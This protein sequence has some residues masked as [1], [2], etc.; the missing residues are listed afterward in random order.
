[1][2]WWEE[3]KGILV[4]ENKRLEDYKLLKEFSFVRRNE[5]LWLLGVVFIDSEHKFPFYFE[6]KYPN[7][8]PFAPP[9]IYPK[10]KSTGW[11]PG[12]QFI[13]EGRFCLDIREYNWL[14]NMSAVNIIESMRIL[15]LASFDK[16]INKRKKLNV[17]EGRE[18]TQLEIKTK[19]IRCLYSRD[20][21]LFNDL[22]GT[23]DYF[24]FKEWEDNRIIIRTDLKD[25]ES[26]FKSELFNIW[27]FNIFFS[28]KGVYIQTNQEI[29]RLVSFCKTLFDFYDLL[30]KHAGIKKEI[31]LDQLKKNDSV[32]VL[33]VNEYKVPILL[34]KIDTKK[35]E[36]QH[37]GCY[38]I[39]FNKLQDRLPNRNNYKILSHKKLQ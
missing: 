31:L 34:I 29:I 38:K 11:V 23:F 14:S 4:R 32:Y 8:Y 20:L 17:K 6:C 3:Q 25:F 27:D 9:Y 5:N 18:P 10:D 7:S 22:Y 2:N 16:Y 39:D 33:L 28:K 13:L 26:F 19:E 15:V 12:H 37:Y 35:N 30:Q 24:S 36:I 21:N 1:M